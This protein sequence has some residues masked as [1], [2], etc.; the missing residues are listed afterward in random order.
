MIGYWGLVIGSRACG[1]RSRADWWLGVGE[2][3]S[4]PA[5]PGRAHARKVREGVG[6]VGARIGSRGCGTRSRAD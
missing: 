5:F 1:T 4:R 2:F 3:F 6:G